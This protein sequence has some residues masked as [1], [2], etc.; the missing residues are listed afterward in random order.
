MKNIYE[1]FDEFTK[2]PSKNEKIDVLRKNKSMALITVLQG[3]F[4]PKIEF[5]VDK[6][7]LYKPSDSPPGLG[8]SSLAL[9]LNRLYLFIKDHPKIPP[10]LTEKRRQ[11]IL[12]QMLE[13]LE[14][15]EA[16]VF[17]NMLMK[18][19]K[20]PGLTSKIVEEAFPGIL[21]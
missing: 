13:V 7:P 19:Q 10:G 12:M 8:Y 21:G 20:V 4:D 11:Q 14:K 18:K 17:M 9:E 5:N 6:V 3:S 2:A 15:R 1:I 16:E